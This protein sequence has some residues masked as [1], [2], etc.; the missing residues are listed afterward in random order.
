MKNWLT[1][2]F[3]KPKWKT[4]A[5][6]TIQIKTTRTFFEIPRQTKIHVYTLVVQISTNLSNQTVKC[7]YTDGI[8]RTYVDIEYV[9]SQCPE[10][11]PVLESNNINY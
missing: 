4:I 1:D 10:I 11:I 9:I 7:F 3:T 8:N 6:G 2:L 5:S